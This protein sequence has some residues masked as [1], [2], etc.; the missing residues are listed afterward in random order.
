MAGWHLPLVLGSGSDPLPAFALVGT[1]AATFWFT[2]TFNR[3]GGSAFMSLVMHAADG[4]FFRF[5]V[6]G[7]VAADAARGL[8]FKVVLVC[9]VTIGLVVFDWK[10]W[11]ASPG[12]HPE[13]SGAGD[14][15]AAARPATP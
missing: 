14:G 7:L 2:W 3:A 1:F 13:T 15:D 11:S 12:R 5:A 4:I 9:A 10:L 6:A 8:L